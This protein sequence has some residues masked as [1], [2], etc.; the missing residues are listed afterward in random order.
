[1]FIY[2]LLLTKVCI[3]ST[4]SRE[5]PEE[6][7]Y[8]KPESEELE[9]NELGSDELELD[10]LELESDELKSDK[11][12]DELELDELPPNRAVSSIICSKS[13]SNRLRSE[14]K[15]IMGSRW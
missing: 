13:P 12:E 5:S 9:S 4:S 11:L 6:E 1:M 2:L 15:G 3:S 10:E 14:T 8:S 7:S